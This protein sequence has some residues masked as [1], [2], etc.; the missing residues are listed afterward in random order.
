MSYQIVRFYARHPNR[1]IADGLT[2][3]EAV[4]RC[5]NPE[6]SSRTCTSP[7]AIE[8]TATWGPWFDG[9]RETDAATPHGRLMREFATRLARDRR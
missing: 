2:Y 3:E 7:E 8:H 9:Y 6:T 1:I 4:E 5:N